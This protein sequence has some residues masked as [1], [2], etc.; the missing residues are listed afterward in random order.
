MNTLTPSDLLPGDVL[1][2]K[3]ADTDLFDQLIVFFTGGPYCHSA[4]WNGT[5][6]VQASDRGI[7]AD[8]LSSLKEEDY[9]D[10]YRFDKNGHTLGQPDWSVDPLLTEA[11]KLAASGQKYAWDHCIL[12]AICCLTRKIPLGPR[13]KKLLRF[14][15]DEAANI[16]DKIIDD[17][18]Q[19]MMCSEVVFTIF[20]EAV[21]VRH[22]ELEIEGVPFQNFQQL[23]AYT[24]TKQSTRYEYR[25]LETYESDA[26]DASFN[27]AQERFV[28]A[29]LRTSA[30][31]K[32]KL[33]ADGNF[34]P[35]VP[36]C[37][38]PY[39]LSQSPDLHLAGRLSF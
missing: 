11:G 16:I 28:K 5:H 12:V 35:V 32:T 14:V 9:V 1:L 18:K 23:C 25:S 24:A 33:G 3:G 4:F 21:P 22:Y 6:V 17:G 31:N 19:P 20:K 7:N 2:C 34:D 15:M 29:W 37:V 39:D 38:T 26:I 10:V 13:E 8:D 30:M 36:A 27:L